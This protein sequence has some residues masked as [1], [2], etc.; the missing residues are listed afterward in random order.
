VT[1]WRE[2]DGIGLVVPFLPGGP[3]EHL[4]TFHAILVVQSGSAPSVYNWS[5][6]A[7]AFLPDTGTMYVPV[8][9]TP[10]AS[11]FDTLE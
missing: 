9:C 10:V 4:W 7:Q 8:T 3:S 2:L 5:F 6:R 11:F 1:K